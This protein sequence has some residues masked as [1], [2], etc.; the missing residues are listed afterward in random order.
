M[1]ATV[2]FLSLY[3]LLE[4][5]RKPKDDSGS[6]EETLYS[7]SLLLKYTTDMFFFSAFWT[8]LPTC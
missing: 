3:F 2:I 6:G 7:K 4:K 1:N 8:Y 5:A